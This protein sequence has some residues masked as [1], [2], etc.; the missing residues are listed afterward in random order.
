MLPQKFDVSRTAEGDQ[1]IMLGFA[2][3]SSFSELSAAAAA[4]ISIS[5]FSLTGLLFRIYST[6]EHESGAER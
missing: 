5:G 1:T 4:A 3:P 2:T 6:S